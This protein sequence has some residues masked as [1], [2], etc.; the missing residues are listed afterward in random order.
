MKDNISPEEKLLRLIKGDKKA[1]VEKKEE[2][3]AK[4]LPA[5]LKPKIN[6]QFNNFIFFTLKKLKIILFVISLVYLAVTFIYP[7]FSSKKINLPA[8]SAQSFKE[9]A[10][11]VSKKEK[12]PFEYYLKDVQ[13]R[14]VFGSFSETQEGPGAAAV[15]AEAD[16]IKDINLLGVVMG[17]NP[18][19]IIEDKKSQKTVYVNRGQ[20]IGQ[21]QVEDIREGKVILNY[22][23]QRYELGV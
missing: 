13:G 19:A 12:K 10:I 23:G 2:P 6:P 20:F 22:K 4:I 18:Q 8:V 15:A 9:E 1:P 17:D 7:Y 11:A 3:A 16:S 5:A 14:Q 21:F